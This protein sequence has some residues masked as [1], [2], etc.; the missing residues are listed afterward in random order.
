MDRYTT[1]EEQFEAL[2]TWW[3]ENGKAVI[4]GVIFGL[5]G[6]TGWRYWQGYVKTQTEQASAA[7]Q[8]LLAQVAD[9]KQETAAQ[10]AKRIIERFEKSPY[11][12]FSALMLAK[13]YVEG[14]EP[15]KAKEQLQWVLDHSSPTEIKWV[16]RLRLARLLLAEGQPDQAWSLVSEMERE[17]QA[18]TLPSYYELK[19]DVL[20]A[21]GKPEEARNAYLQALA[22]SGS[23]GSPPSLLQM[24]LDD[25]GE[26]STAPG[27]A[28]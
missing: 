20:I 22:L 3:K 2:K 27:Q 13:L 17:Q 12:V 25:L 8:R 14:N 21:Q 28:P 6:L 15:A 1:D 11:A 4:A 5:I 7:Y 18:A 26:V 16:A 9:H 23:A 10:G 19:G 24:K